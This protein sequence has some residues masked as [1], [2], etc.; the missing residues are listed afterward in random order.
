MINLLKMIVS[1]LVVTLIVLSLAIAIYV[2]KNHSI[3]WF[4][5]SAY[6]LILAI[7]DGFHWI[8]KC[9]KAVE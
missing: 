3:P 4:L 2:A 9:R 7:K 6:W 1:V 5:A 8:L